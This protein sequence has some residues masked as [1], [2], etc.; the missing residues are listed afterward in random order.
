MTELKAKKSLG[1][2][3]LR[4]EDALK[5]IV[6]ASALSPHDLVLEIG[7]GEGVLTEALL[8]G[9]AKV[10]AVE[11]DERAIHLLA[12]RFSSAILDSRLVLIEGDI[13]NTAIQEVLFDEIHLGDRAY[14]LIANIPYY[15]TGYLFRL[16]LET[17]RQ[18]A[19]MVFL[20]QKEVAEQIVAKD[21]K[22]GMLSLSV[23]AFGSPR[24]IATVTREAFSP[25]PKVDSAI[26]LI[27][28]ISR[29]HFTNI[30]TQ[31]YFSVLKAGL[32][33]KRKM[34]F[35]NLAQSFGIPKTKLSEIFAQL[36][37]PS[38]IRGEDLSIDAWLRLTQRIATT[39]RFSK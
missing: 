16:F 38:S 11:T 25:P 18:P 8:S 19:L 20:V 33:S 7:P 10:I 5:E 22:E 34:L 4:S 27:E 3:F 12:E 1:Q 13:R 39:E 15:I 24:Y 29:S 17:L 2:H 21:K 9:G 36:D 37:I 31:T 32:G 6:G 28:H 30:D 35:G 26:I 23:K 14:K